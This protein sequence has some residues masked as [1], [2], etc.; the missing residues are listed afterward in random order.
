MDTSSNYNSSVDLFVEIRS[1]DTISFS[2]KDPIVQASNGDHQHDSGMRH[3]SEPWTVEPESRHHTA[4]WDG[5]SAL[6]D[7]TSNG[8]TTRKEHTA[9]K[10]HSPGSMPQQMAAMNAVPEECKFL[11][12][13]SS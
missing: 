2:Y 1:Q 7:G 13:S 11:A 5:I 10:P 3:F 12:P 4:R 9:A 8:S 6:W